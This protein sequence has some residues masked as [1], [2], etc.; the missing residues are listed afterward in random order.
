MTDDWKLP[1]GP[2]I[3]ADVPEEEDEPLTSDQETA[4]LSH[5]WLTVGL[6]IE[7]LSPR[8]I[9]QLRFA[10]WQHRNNRIPEVC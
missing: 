6:V 4:L 2:A 5:P 7:Y 3:V 9:E 8:E 1:R 10:R